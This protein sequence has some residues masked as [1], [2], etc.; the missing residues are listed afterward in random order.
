MQHQQLVGLIIVP[1]LERRADVEQEKH[2][3]R[4]AAAQAVSADAGRCRDGADQGDQQDVNGKRGEFRQPG[5]FRLARR[6]SVS[7]ATT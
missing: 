6:P 2:R 5:A 4:I 3:H 1:R 7:A